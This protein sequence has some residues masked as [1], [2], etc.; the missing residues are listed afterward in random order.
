MSIYIDGIKSN[1]VIPENF[2]EYNEEK[3][4]QW[5]S[6]SFQI[7]IEEIKELNKYL[8]KMP[9]R[10]TNM[11][12]GIGAL[13]VKFEQFAD[14]PSN[15]YKCMNYKFSYEYDGH[16]IMRDMSWYYD[17]HG[18][19]CEEMYP[20]LIPASVNSN[21]W[22]REVAKRETIKQDTK[23]KQYSKTNYYG[24]P[25]DLEDKHKI[26][27]DSNGNKIYPIRPMKYQSLNGLWILIPICLFLCLTGWGGVIF[28]IIAMVVYLKYA[29]KEA[30]EIWERDCEFYSHL[31]S[32]YSNNFKQDPIDMSKV[33]N[34]K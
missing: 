25:I 4:K 32:P 5:A 19:P 2:K 14:D 12:E 20:K 31:K 27:I 6:E 7:A 21:V 15:Y 9:Y 28:S 23:R 16:I 33:N 13:S 1:I 22:K 26:T 11:R 29:E 10:T 24:T 34:K 17:N 18:T 30:Q 8:N 3:R